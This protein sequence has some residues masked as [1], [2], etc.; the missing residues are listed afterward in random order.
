MEEAARALLELEIEPLVE[1]A[2]AH[3]SPE[4][5]R[6]VVRKADEEGA[7]AIIAAAGYAAHS[8]GAVDA[9]SDWL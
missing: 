9:G 5:V 3:R 1:V 8:A 6:T 4:R 2:S 7:E